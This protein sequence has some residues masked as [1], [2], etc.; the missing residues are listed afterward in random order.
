M[1]T[2]TSRCSEL[3]SSFCRDSG[4][5]VEHF[6]S[7]AVPAARC[8]RRPPNLDV[9]GITS[10]PAAAGSRLLP[11][12]AACGAH[13]K[14]ATEGEGHAGGASVLM[15]RG[16]AQ[17]GENWLSS[18]LTN[19]V[20]WQ[21]FV[22]ALLLR[23]VVIAMQPPPLA[24][25]ESVAAG[26]TLSH[27][28]YLGDPFKIPTG[29]TAHVAPV[30]PLVVAVVDH[31]THDEARTVAVLRVFMA[32]VSALNVALLIPVAAAMGLPPGT[33][34]A[35]GLLWLVPLYSWIELSAQ[36]ET[37]LVVTAIL[38][39]LGYAVN[40]MRQRAWSF[41]SGA[42]LGLIT[43]LA[44]HLSPLLLPMLGASVAAGLAVERAAIRRSLP[45]ISGVL[46]LFML[47]ILPYTLRNYVHF[48][49]VFLIRD[50][51][52]LELAM[53]NGAN[54]QAT[55]KANQAAG[56]TMRGHP[57]LSSTEAARL[58]DTGE[59]QYN[60][61]RMHDAVDWIATNPRAF[62]RLTIRRVGYMLLPPSERVYQRLHA[63][64]VV[65]LFGAG[66]ILLGNGACQLPIWMLTASVA[67]YSAVLILLEQDIRYMYPA[68][69]IESL[70]AGA[71]LV[72][73]LSRSPTIAS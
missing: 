25:L 12:S 66:L 42:R 72:S 63:L 64:L 4:P 49:S 17:R 16:T 43:G 46:L 61:I 51:F 28:G 19:L 31:F 58:R 26:L 33:G 38:L 21:L 39:L 2:V 54:A 13:A 52:G 60:R 65:L 6:A 50:N 45:F 8:P 68:L 37:V 29:V 30:Y 5:H 47:A 11:S 70:V 71:L 41:G 55:A 57:F 32:L 48:H 15:Q 62:A 67:G 20:P 1:A 18:R 53:S 34:A 24:R 14:G 9:T 22:C 44:V 40:R 69:W 7:S 35:A 36:N 27:K 10:G 73:R 23:L 56:G 3:A 59:V